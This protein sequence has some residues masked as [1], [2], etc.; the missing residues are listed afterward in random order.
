MCKK[1]KVCGPCSLK[2]KIEESKNP[3]NKTLRTSLIKETQNAIEAINR[4][5]IT[6][7]AAK[8]KNE[9]LL[10]AIDESF[11]H[12]NEVLNKLIEG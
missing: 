1:N 10:N 11:E 7:D 6:A 5:Y 4:F 9:S 3:I 8:L 2:K 12:L